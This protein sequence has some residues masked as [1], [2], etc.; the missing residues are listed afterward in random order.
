MSLISS[1]LALNRAFPWSMNRLRGIAVALVLGFSLI[2]LAGCQPA[3]AINVK[4][5][6]GI[7]THGG[8]YY[9]FNEEGTYVTAASADA[10]TSQPIEYGDFRLEGTTLTFI[11]DEESGFCAGKT[12]SYEVEIAEEGRIEI[13]VVEDSCSERAR[14][15]RNV[16]LN[17]YSP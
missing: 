4:D 15:Q 16:F 17:R 8:S 2:L 14:F 3:S 12:G 7:W 6:I 13:T 11:T 10:L 9:Q 1:V 5:L